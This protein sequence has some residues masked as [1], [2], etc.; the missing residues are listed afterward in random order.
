MADELHPSEKPEEEYLVYW[1]IK[2][3]R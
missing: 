3:K 1:R 2:R